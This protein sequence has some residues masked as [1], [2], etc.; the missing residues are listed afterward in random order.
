VR[1][2]S[3]TKAFAALVTDTLSGKVR[4]PLTAEQRAALAADAAEQDELPPLLG[5]AYDRL[6][7]SG[8][9]WLS[10]FKREH[11]PVDKED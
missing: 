4:W 5:S 10:R 9:D 7:D 6:L 3:T 11:D 2:I 8:E 1:K